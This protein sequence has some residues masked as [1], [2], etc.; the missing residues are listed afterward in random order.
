MK[1]LL[2]DAGNSG[3]KWAFLDNGQLS[4][5]QS[6]LY[7][8]S[9]PFDK[10]KDI[11][12][13][14]LIENDIDKVVMVSVL[15][16]NYIS[17]VKKLSQDAKLIFI[18]AKPLEKLAGVTSAYSEPHKLGPDRLVAMIAAYHLETTHASI[19]IDSGT[20]TT[21]DAVDAQGQHLGGLILPG[22]DLC[23]QSLLEKT[24]MLA[25]F[26]KSKHKYEPSIFSTNTKQAIASGSLFGLV[27][28]IEN[29]CLM[30]EKEIRQKQNSNIVI[31][32]LICGGSASKLLP[33]LSKEFIH[34]EDLIMQGLKNISEQD[35]KPN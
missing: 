32:K 14:Q 31:K 16:D 25:S 17:A 26:N 34:H 13:Q 20:A 18:N 24:E 22:L 30:M 10:F 19:V 1:K 29:I 2:V 8:N 35:K 27:G 23:S 12:E 33:Y 5:M 4:K 15:G 21:I 3:I 9:T 28:A 11:F 7:E 6:N